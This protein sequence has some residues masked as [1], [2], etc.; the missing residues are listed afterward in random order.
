[1]LD[2]AEEDF[3]QALELGIAHTD[4]ALNLDGLVSAIHTGLGQC[5]RLRDDL[6]GA[7]AAYRRAIDACPDDLAAKLLLGNVLCDL[8]R[9]DEAERSYD[10]CIEVRPDFFEAYYNLADNLERAGRFE[11]AAEAF[12]RAADLRPD[13]ADAHLR[14][15]GLYFRE[16]EFARAARSFRR[17]RNADPSRAEPLLGCA[18]AQLALDH[19]WQ[20]MQAAKLA[21]LLPEISDQLRKHAEMISTEADDKLRGGLPR[22][23]TNSSAGLAGRPACRSGRGGLESLLRSTVYRSALLTAMKPSVSVP[24]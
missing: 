21:M 7:E 4:L 20:A 15:G 19:P 2:A 9:H 8:G 16:N 1:L 24:S 13:L 23:A 12:A 22:Q 10:D 17:A 6:A 11:D 5:R 3:Q 18:T 14:L